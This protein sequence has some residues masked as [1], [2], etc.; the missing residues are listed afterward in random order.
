MRMSKTEMISRL[1]MGYIKTGKL[2]LSQP[3][4][5]LLQNHLKPLKNL[6][7]LVNKVRLSLIR[8]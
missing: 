5:M 4:C 7:I 3:P 2:Q 6:F 1:G 8:A